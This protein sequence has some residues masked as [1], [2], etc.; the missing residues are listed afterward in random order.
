GAVVPGSCTECHL[1]GSAT[2]DQWD[3]SQWRAQQRP[4]SIRLFTKFDHTPH[5]SIPTVSDCKYCHRING[6][7]DA[8]AGK[9]DADAIS[10]LKTLIASSA[11]TRLADGQSRYVHMLTAA[12]Q[13]THDEFSP[14]QR[15][16]CIACH[17]PG[18]AN[19]RCTQCHNYHVGTQGFEFSH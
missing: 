2:S 15:A 5:L 16:D 10:K 11:K 12:Q 1:V 3:Q 14:M 8:L 19:D 6:L 13:C 9:L 7:D 4:D 18:A 17:R